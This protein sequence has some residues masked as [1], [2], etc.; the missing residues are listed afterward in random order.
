[1]QDKFLIVPG[2]PKSGTTFLYDQFARNE[3]HFNIPVRKELGAFHESIT[4]KNYINLFETTNSQKVYL[5]ATPSYADWRSNALR[6]MSATLSQ[7]DVFIMFCLRDPM[8]RA[9]SHYLHDLIRNFWIYAFDVYQFEDP[10]VFSRYFQPT[11]QQIRQAKQLFG[12][13]RVVGWSPNGDSSAGIESVRQF[14]GLPDNWVLDIHA[15]RHSG[16]WLPKVFYDSRKPLLILDGSQLYEIPS[17]TL[18]VSNGPRS[19]LAT[20]FPADIGDQLVR[21]SASWTRSF[22]FQ[23]LGDNAKLLVDDFSESL[24]QCRIFGVKAATVERVT[25]AQPPALPAVIRTKLR[26]ICD[27]ALSSDSERSLSIS[28]PSIGVLIDQVDQAYREISAS[29]SSEREAEIKMCELLYSVIGE[30]GPVP[31]YVEKYVKLSVTL[32]RHENVIKYF[33]N[34]RSISI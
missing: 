21:A 30:F 18:L 12:V 3:A 28:R 20:E 27:I 13:D 26:I 6:N 34:H 29:G 4:K 16:G 10:R 14:A 11:A 1:M 8:S 17:G 24:E 15:E 19:I 22:D 25:A 23:V 33:E 31:E 5:D 2:Y 32:G 7:D 9:Y